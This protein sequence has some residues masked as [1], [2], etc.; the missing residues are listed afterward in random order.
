MA[1]R[2]APLAFVSGSPHQFAGRINAFLRKHRFP[3]AALYLRNYGPDTLS[4]YKQPVI[5][6][7]LRSFDQN[8]VLVGDSGEHDPE[9]YADILREFPGRV[10]A[11][12]IHDVG[13]SSTD[14]KRYEGMTLFKDGT[15]LAA[16]ARKRGLLGESCPVGAEKE[17]AR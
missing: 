2:G 7:L 13:S 1:Q 6:R 17:E 12:Y 11:V 4:G 10:L 8:V 16:D 14:P 3:P 5:R 9:V 15:D